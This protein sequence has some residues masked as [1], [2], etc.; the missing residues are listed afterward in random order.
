[1]PFGEPETESKLKPKTSPA[2]TA[3]VQPVKVEDVPV[4]AELSDGF[5]EAV[6]V[7]PTVGNAALAFQT[8]IVHVQEAL[9]TMLQDEI[10]PLYGT[11]T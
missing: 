6:I 8:S 1:M 11:L 3:V 5:A 7:L 9:A 2:A 4:A 10:I